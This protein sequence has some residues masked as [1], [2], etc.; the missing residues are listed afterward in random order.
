[1]YK[2]MN[3]KKHDKRKRHILTPRYHK[4]ISYL[5]HARMIKSSTD[6]TLQNVKVF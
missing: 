1:M 5:P 3:H 2:E 6:F 4:Q